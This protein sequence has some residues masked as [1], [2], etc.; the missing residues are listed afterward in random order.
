[1]SIPFIHF[2]MSP[3][4]HY[5]TSLYAIEIRATTLIR[6]KKKRNYKL[7]SF[8]PNKLT[9]KI[10]HKMHKTR[11]VYMVQTNLKLKISRPICIKY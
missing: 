5:P 10:E 8:Q 1:M 4:V 2:V 7:C 9:V 11:I 6:L 3:T